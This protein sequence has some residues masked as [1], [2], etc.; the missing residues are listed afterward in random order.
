[1][2]AAGQRFRVLAGH[3]AVCR[4]NPDAPVP[5]WANGPFVSVTATRD[6]LS[7]IC[8][9]ERVPDGVQ[10]ERGWR[11][12]Q[13]VG[14]FALDEVGV[15]ASVAGPLAQA[16]ISLLAMATYDTDYVLVRESACERAV[17]TLRSAGHTPVD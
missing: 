17:A 10:G 11:V 12:F 2:N 14:P 1:V 7:V 9:A 6:E 4:L 5:T 16:G 3:Y 15:M 13:L 8:P